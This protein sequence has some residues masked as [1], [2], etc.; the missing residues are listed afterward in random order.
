MR[1]RFRTILLC[2]WMLAVVSGLAA[3]S[4]SVADDVAARAVDGELSIMQF[5]LDGEWH[6]VHSNTPGLKLSPGNHALG[7]LYGQVDTDEHCMRLRYKFEGIDKQWKELGS[8]GMRVTVRFQN[9]SNDIVGENNFKVLGDSPGWRGAITNSWFVPSQQKVVIPEGAVKMVLLLVSGGPIENLG[10]LVIDDLKVVVKDAQTGREELW[11]NEDFERGKNMDQVTGTPLNWVRGGLRRDTLQ[12]I[13]CGE[14]PTN[15]AL[16]ALDFHVRSFGEWYYTVDL[17]GHAKPGDTLNVEWRQ[18]YS[19]GVGGRYPSVYD[20]VPPGQYTFRV[21][22]LSVPDGA[23]VASVALPVDVPVTFLHSITFVVLCAGIGSAVVGV[24]ARVLTRRR[25]QL[26]MERMKWQ[27]A[28]ERERTRIARDIHDDIGSGLTRISMLS[29]SARDQLKS[30]LTPLDE[31]NE[32]SS[33]TREI[34]G[35]LDE[36]VWAV[37]PSHDKLDSLVAYCGNYAQDFFKTTGIKCRLDLDFNVPDWT[38]SSQ[39]RHNLFLSFKEILNNTACHARAK[40]VR[41]SF[42]MGVDSCTLAVED[43]GQGFDP[44][45]ISRNNGLNNMRHRLDEIGGECRI[46]SR[47]GTG[48]TVSLIMKRQP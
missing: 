22:G 25:M 13:Q 30:S 46:T 1:L 36:I 10:V 43:D 7:F 11:L 9:S 4:A 19:V 8:E 20:F 44:E 26:Q 32:I 23:V 21:V 41:I 42:T 29:D 40:L 6:N 17:E 31:L 39:A 48:T 47:V 12:V 27:Q 14:A 38:L 3:Q 15:H 45:H 35:A 34:V 37:N 16:A 28:L 5:Q 33:T 24:G 18:L 2:A